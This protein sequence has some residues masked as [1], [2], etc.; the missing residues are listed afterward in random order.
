[1]KCHWCDEPL[2]VDWRDTKVFATFDA[3]MDPVFFCSAICKR[4]YI[5]R[6]EYNKARAK[7]QRKNKSP[8]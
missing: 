6:R 3:K 8:E 5:D 2:I 4:N 1:M 7:E